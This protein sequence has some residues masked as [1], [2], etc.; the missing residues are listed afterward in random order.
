MM[1][2][3]NVD[4]YITGLNNIV[5]CLK[6]KIYGEIMSDIGGFINDISDNSMYVVLTDEQRQK[7]INDQFESWMK[8]CDELCRD[9]HEED[10][11]NNVI[12]L[13]GAIDDSDSDSNVMADDEKDDSD[14]SEDNSDSDSSEDN[15]DSDSSSMEEDDDTVP[16]T[17]LM[18]ANI[19]EAISLLLITFQDEGLAMTPRY[20]IVRL[21]QEL[22][23]LFPDQTA[24]ALMIHMMHHFISERMTEHVDILLVIDGELSHGDQAANM[25][26]QV[27]ADGNE[28]GEM[29][30]MNQFMIDHADSM[31]LNILNS[32]MELTNL[33]N[34]I[35]LPQN[36]TIQTVEDIER[37]SVQAPTISQDVLSNLSE[38]QYSLLKDPDK[39][40]QICCEDYVPHDT[41][42]NLSCNHIFH[43]ECVT[44]WLTGCNSCCPLCKEKVE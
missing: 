17:Q 43:K 27:D 41:V 39:S 6:R 10:A 21:I 14:S 42:I 31:P 13:D 4:Q 36:F 40:C 23:E 16:A 18:E 24:D 8:V 37:R 12:E 9:I 32:V 30:P 2:L 25:M 44:L 15:S 26:V 29:I 28:I 33:A 11:C 3:I 19:L 7:S 38:T 1:M 34:N 5:Y 20:M 35:E 22:Q